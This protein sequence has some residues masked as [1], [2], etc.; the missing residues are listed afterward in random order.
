MQAMKL[1]VE[2][3]S[4]GPGPREVVVSFET[5]AGSAEQVIVDVRSL[6]GTFVNVGYPLRRDQKNY[7]VELPRETTRG[8]WRVWVPESELR[9]S[10]AGE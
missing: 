9:S 7:L 2:K 5:S 10:E 3:V 6:S 1:K 8:A 4:D